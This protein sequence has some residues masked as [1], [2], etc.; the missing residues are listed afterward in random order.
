MPEGP[1]IRRA[2]DQLAAALVDQ[3]TTQVLFAFERL[4]KYQ[5]RLTGAT[6]TAVQTRGKAMLIHFD[7]GWV[8][9]SHN[10]LYGLWRICQAGEQ[11]ETNRQLRLAI[12][13]C[14]QSALLYSASDI[15]V[16]KASAVAQQPFIA[17]LGPDLLSEKPSADVILARLNSNRFQKRQFAS[18]LLDQSFV[19]GLGNYLRAEIL[20][21][22]KLHPQ[23]R[24]IDCSQTELKRLA[25]QILKITYRA[26]RTN[27]ISNPPSLVKKLKAL[28][29]THKE[30]Y[31]FSVYGRADK[32]C[33]HCRN[34]VQRINAGGRHIYFCPGC[35]P[36]RC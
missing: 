32:N 28:G 17:K 30:A 29:H 1:E 35:Q 21:F 3:A 5:R 34:H 33:Y 16:I 7:N 12:H 15:D 36:E 2:A 27:G 31:R 6:I 8:I 11:P 24:P 25:K 13:N 23:R 9:Y 19:A 10:Q 20:Y 22:A 14:R 18:L 4:K 26:Y